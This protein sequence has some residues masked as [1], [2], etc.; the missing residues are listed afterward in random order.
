VIRLRGGPRLSHPAIVEWVAV[1]LP[2]E[3]AHVCH[4]PVLCTSSARNVLGCRMMR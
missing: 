4:G 3:E 1:S 2:L